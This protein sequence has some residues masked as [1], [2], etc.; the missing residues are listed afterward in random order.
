MTA[1]PSLRFRYNVQYSTLVRWTA[2]GGSMP[3]P[4]ECWICGELLELRIIRTPHPAGD[5]PVYR[6]PHC[7]FVAKAIPNAQSADKPR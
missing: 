2:V 6:C 1:D 3:Q 7:H 5:V 4:P